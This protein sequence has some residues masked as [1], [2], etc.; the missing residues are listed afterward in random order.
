METPE[1][2]TSLDYC[3]E[4]AEKHLQTTTILLKEALQRY[5]QCHKTNPCTPCCI[6]EKP[7]LEKIRDTIAE[8]TGAEDDTNPLTDN[9]MVKD[10]NT[11]IRNIRKEIWNKKLAFG[12]GT[13]EDITNIA[14]KIKTLTDYIYE[15]Y[16][17]QTYEAEIEKLIQSTNTELNQ[18][19]LKTEQTTDTAIQK[20]KEKQQKER[21]Q[22]QEKKKK[23]KI[24]LKELAEPTPEE[25]EEAL[26]KDMINKYATIALNMK[27]GESE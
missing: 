1:K 26:Y 15:N 17:K 11:Q 6:S 18:E 25:V 4:C 24:N 3:L 20:A 7:V 14:Q 5:E 2:G 16:T 8:L 9:T 13:P 10:I 12:Q 19:F 23:P 21:Q 27:T 22:K